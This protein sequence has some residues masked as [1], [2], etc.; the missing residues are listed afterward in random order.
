MRLE[1]GVDDPHHLIIRACYTVWRPEHTHSKATWGTTQ[2]GLILPTLFNFI[3]VNVVRNWRE[4][5]V[6]GQLVAHK[7]L[8]LTAGRCLVIF[9]PGDSVVVSWYLKWL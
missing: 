9:Y 7:G 6:E 2:G 3:V 5:T 4:L 1:S 8:V